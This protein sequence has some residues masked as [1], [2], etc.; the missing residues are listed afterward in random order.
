MEYKSGMRL[1]DLTVEDKRSVFFDLLN[2]PGWMILAEEIGEGIKD[3]DEKRR[4]MQD[5]SLIRYSQ[6]HT[7]ALVDIIAKPGEWFQQA[8]DEIREKEERK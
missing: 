1:Q 4:G 3:D 7:A 8:Y 2:S 5:F 6:G